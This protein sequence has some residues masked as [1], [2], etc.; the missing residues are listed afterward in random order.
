MKSKGLVILLF[1]NGFIASC[2]APAQR[3]TPADLTITRPGAT[4][5]V[6]VHSRTGNTAAVGLQISDA[7]RSDYIRLKSPDGSGDNYMNAPNRNKD[8]SVEPR[9]VDMKK[10]GIIFLG[11]PIWYW[12]ANAFIYTFVRNND[13]TGKRVVLF[14]T[15]EGGISDDAVDEWKSLVQKK[16]GNV[17]DV[18]S[19]NRKKFK[20]S[21]ALVAEIKSIIGKHKPAWTG[22]MK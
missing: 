21:E 2:T 22:R 19:I 9:N 4:S 5:L 13:F 17:V 6:V 7:L 8:A 10:Y 1:L 12:H 15:Y 18:V 11:S 20:T 3:L 14:Y 16:G